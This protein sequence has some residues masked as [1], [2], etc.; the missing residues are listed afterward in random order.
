M[1]QISVRPLNA[2]TQTTV[3]A[4]ISLEGVLKAT[5]QLI[6]ADHG[7]G[8]S[9][10][11]VEVSNDG[12]NWVTYNK[13]ITNVTNTNA[14]MLTRVGSVTLSSNTSSMVALDLSQDVFSWMRVTV[15][16]TTDGTHS[17]ICDL[18]LAK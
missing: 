3:S 15:T 10:F 9:A 11:I 4:P 6:R 18:L 2:V 1:R 5:I 13:L 16:E 17:A 7:S 12:I 8:S 14:Q